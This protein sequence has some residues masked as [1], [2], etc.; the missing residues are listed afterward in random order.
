MKRWHETCSL[1]PKKSFSRL[2]Y[3]NS[4]HI[5]PSSLPHEANIGKKKKKKKRT[6]SHTKNF[7][8]GRFDLG[9]THRTEKLG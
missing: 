9:D 1:V 8:G 2:S 4:S 6:Q 3:S 7:H 5:G